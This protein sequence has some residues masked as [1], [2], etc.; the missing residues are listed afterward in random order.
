MSQQIQ[1][2]V[3]NSVFGKKQ[4]GIINFLITETVISCQPPRV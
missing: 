4:K 3:K 2:Q 1:H